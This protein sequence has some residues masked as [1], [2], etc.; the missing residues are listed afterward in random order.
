MVGLASETCSCPTSVASIGSLIRCAASGNRGLPGTNHDCRGSGHWATAQS[1]NPLRKFP[2]GAQRCP[3]A[4]PF[5]ALCLSSTGAR[6]VQHGRVRMPWIIAMGAVWA[7]GPLDGD[8]MDL[9]INSCL[10]REIVTCARLVVARLAH[11]LLEFHL[12][13][14]K[15]TK[16]RSRSCMRVSGVAGNE[17]RLLLLP[18]P[19]GFPV[20]VGRTERHGTKLRVK[21]VIFHFPPALLCQLLCC[22]QSIVEV[23]PSPPS[24]PL[25][26]TSTASEGGYMSP[27]W[28]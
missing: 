26:D 7:R 23:S 6:K 12:P 27:S 10:F 17:H 9:P 3:T 20:H 5:I 22:C 24:P 19:S 25:L 8:R 18:F 15:Q 1:C 13:G 28:I 11:L 16:S 2:S 21:I 4:S 14:A